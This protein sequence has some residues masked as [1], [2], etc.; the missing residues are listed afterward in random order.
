MSKPLRVLNIEDSIEDS[1]RLTTELLRGDYDLEYKRVETPE[2]MREA[3]EQ[4][5]WDIVLSDYSMPNFTGLDALEIFKQSGLDLPFIIVSGAIG[6]ETAVTVLK[7]GAHDFISKDNLARL[8]PAIERELKDAEVRREH[9]RAQEALAESE[10]KFRT[11]TQSTKDA[12]I[13][14]DNEGNI[15]EFNQSAEYMFGYSPDEAVGENLHLLL[16]P[17]RHREAHSKAFAEFRK[18]GKGAVI[19]QTI[20]LEGIRK[21]GKEFPLELSLS[22]FQLGGLWHAAG[23]IRDISARKQLEI[24]LRQAQ[25]M[26]SV[27]TLAAGIAHEINTP[28]QFVG[29]NNRFLQDS[30]K[31]INEILVKCKELVDTYQ[32]GTLSPDKIAEFKEAMAAADIDYLIEEIPQALQQS[33]RGIKSISTIVSAMRS[34][35]HPGA[36]EKISVDINNAIQNTIIVSKNEWK[37]V[38]DLET[39]F[40]T[41]LPQVPCHLG[42][43]NQAILNLIVNAAQAISDAIRIKDDKLEPV[44]DTGQ[45]PLDKDREHVENKGTITIRT[46]RVENYVEIHISDTGT[47][48]PEEVRGRIFDPF[49]TTKDVGKGTGQGLSL[50]HSVIVEKHNGD[51]TFVT[52]MGKGT[53]F[54]IRLPLEVD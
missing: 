33:E 13:L 3:L 52:E 54:V 1:L 44:A 49:F 25:K 31:D 8:L 6:E 37:Y 36:V 38:A 43:F 24:Q 47:G 2:A 32:D 21:D 29:N 45:A 42:E 50:V 27:G 7:A 17:L 46:L 22:A 51:I 26:E 23:I 53:T 9:R 40:D 10:E 28:T 12:I 11:I 39:D 48:I 14:M 15:S 5:K 19:G 16:A 20:E 30:F 34:F 18:S 35:A 4:N 41:S